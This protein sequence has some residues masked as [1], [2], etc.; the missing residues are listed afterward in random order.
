[1]PEDYGND[2]LPSV[3]DQT[4]VGDLSQ[5]LQD[6]LVELRGKIQQDDD[7]RAQWKTKCIVANNQRLGVKR[8]S[9]YPYPGA[10]D[11]PLPETDKLIKKQVPNLVLSAWAPK[12]L[13]LVSVKPGFAPNPDWEQKAKRSEEAVN[14]VMRSPEMDWFNKLCLAA[15]Y[16]KEKGHA[17]FRAREEFKSRYVT[18][19]IELSDY[20]PEIIKQL[21]KA[22]KE[23]LRMFIAE[24]FMLDLESEDDVE[25]IDDA[26]DQFKK[27]EEV[28]EI[29]YEEIESFPM[30][31]IPLPTK[32]IVPSYTT[33][34]RYATRVTYE[35]FLT[36]QEIERLMDKG[37][38][39]KKDLDSMS[40]SNADQD[41]VEAQKERNEGTTSNLSNGELYRI[42]ECLCW[43][44]EEGEWCRKV[45]V[46]LADSTSP[47]ESLLADIYFPFEFDGW[48]FVKYDN[49]V[50]D[51]RYYSS[52]GTPEQIR[53]YQ[54]IMERG[55]N[56][57]LIRDE[58]NNTPMWEVAQGSELLD[59]HIRFVPGARLPVKNLGTEVQAIGL[60]ATPD[61]SSNLIMQIIKGHVEEYQSSNDYLFRNATN[62]GGGK[63]LGEVSLGMQ[64]NSK[65]L[66]LEVTNWNNALS[67]VYRMVF[68]ILAERL[69]E[70]MYLPDGTEVTREDFN[71]PADVR[72]NGDI[73]IA[74]QQLQS[75]RAM[76]RVQVLLNPA[77]ADVV[78]P[79]DR[80]NILRDWLEKE[81]A[82]DPDQFIT[83]P[84]EM[85]QDK[86]V[87]M[88]QQLQQAQQQLMMM[89]QQR[90]KSIKDLE[91][92]KQKQKE[93]QAKG[94]AINEFNV[95]DILNGQPALNQ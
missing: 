1:M 64:S 24:R 67:K 50:K 22:T 19:V 20:D 48:N 52:R 6:F 11:F 87:Q 25:A 47:E 70:S 76:A 32:V 31:D 80:Y 68:D 13:C 5:E 73:E 93:Q 18:K 83:S 37:V 66:N 53:A 3:K 62:A 36:R 17:I 74:D 27:G 15:D 55:I 23:E 26:I 21:K 84:M 75:Q 34:I 28:I 40:F 88:A 65:S 57:M 46:L 71:F 82:K 63:T 77:L 12:K 2:K 85:A 86:S 7:D 90:Q 45:F 14:M 49:E 60:Q 43:Q 59:S 81:G 8:Y 35:Y 38:Y 72:S 4:N 89:D 30:V 78:S 42:H 39:R 69:G 92:L 54:E 79:E 94:E 51:P 56:N 58:M 41:I 61:L 9:E 33:D 44:K 16:A 91:S 95:E 10:P 29:K